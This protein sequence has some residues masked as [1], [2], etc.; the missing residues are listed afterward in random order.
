MRTFS[1]LR[2]DSHAL[3]LGNGTLDAWEQEVGRK[4]VPIV[5]EKVLPE[6]LA[7]FLAALAPGRP[8]QNAGT[9][10]MNLPTKLRSHYVLGLRG[11]GV[12][13]DTAWIKING[14]YFDL[15]QPSAGGGEN[16]FSCYELSMK[17]LKLFMKK[18][19]NCFPELRTYAN[20]LRLRDSGGL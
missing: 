1:E 15:A 9:V 10:T 20:F 5:L 17:D 12:M 7:A 14:R 16:C 8:F 6:E 2:T 11:D 4:F 3:H 19:R 18:S 13:T